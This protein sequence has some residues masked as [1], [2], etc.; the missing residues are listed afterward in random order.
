MKSKW[1]LSVER[2]K[3]YKVASAYEAQ[4]MLMEWQHGMACHDM[5]AETFITFFPKNPKNNNKFMNDIAI[6]RCH[7]R[8]RRHHHCVSLY[9]IHTWSKWLVGSALRIDINIFTL[10]TYTPCEWM[11]NIKSKFP[12]SFSFSFPLHCVA[13]LFCFTLLHL[14]FSSL[15]PSCVS[16]FRFWLSFHRIR[17]IISL[18][19][20]T[21][22]YT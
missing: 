6:F 1:A 9:I 11:Q 22:T 13:L 14:S 19:K 7:H 2:L 12:R 17:R 16:V 10:Y 5:A 20:D 8:H 18:L 3:N 4:I 15:Q 21:L